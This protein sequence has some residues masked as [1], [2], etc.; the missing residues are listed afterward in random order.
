M[1]LMATASCCFYFVWQVV[2]LAGVDDTVMYYIT[3]F[4][5]I[6]GLV[7]FGLLFRFVRVQVQLK[8]SEENS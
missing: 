1:M 6:A 5:K 7:N 8:A 4:F 3:P 2:Y